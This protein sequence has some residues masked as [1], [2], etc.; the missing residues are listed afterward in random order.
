VLRD[1]RHPRCRNVSVLAPSVARK[2]GGTARPAA[3]RSAVS[4]GLTLPQS[5]SDVALIQ[6]LWRRPHRSDQWRALRRRAGADGLARHS[7]RRRQRRLRRRC[8]LQRTCTHAQTRRPMPRVSG[9][10]GALCMCVRACVSARGR[11]DCSQCAPWRAA[12]ALRRPPAHTANAPPQRVHPLVVRIVRAERVD[13][14]HVVVLRGPQRAEAVHDNLHL[15]AATAQ[16]AAAV[17][18][19][20]WR[21]RAAPRVSRWRPLGAQSRMRYRQSCNAAADFQRHCQMYSLPA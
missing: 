18:R 4:R 21:R 1:R 13:A 12:A 8:R 16:V 15:H 10:G 7:V 19:Q 5:T 9:C 11:R 2:S 17:R 14:H 20:R 6:L 3:L